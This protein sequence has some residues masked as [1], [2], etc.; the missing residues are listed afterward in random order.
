MKIDFNPHAAAQAQNARGPQAQPAP[1]A[2]EGSDDGVEITL[3]QAAKSIL[4]SGDGEY[5]GNS[6]AHKAR[7]FIATGLA[8]ASAEGG[9]TPDFSGPFGQI[10]KTFA[11]GHNKAPEVVEEPDVV[12]EDGGDVGGITEPT[13]GGDTTATD[14]TTVTDGTDGTGGTG[15]TDGGDTAV[16]D[17][18]DGGSET[19]TTE[20][21]DATVVA[22]PQ[23]GAGTGETDPIVVVE[24]PDIIEILDESAPG[25]G[26]A[27]EIGSGLAGSGDAVADGTDASGET[28]T[29]E[30]A[31]AAVVDGGDV[32]DELLELLDA[33]AEEVV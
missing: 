26:E 33:D 28:G 13:D 17:G 18:S 19:G 3:S 8:T 7:Q 32:T 12:P 6:P 9:E 4:K 29:T 23:D 21:D 1:P 5:D 31:P 27:G 20:G 16:T 14:G 30:G 2:P 10:V 25:D 22:A 15:T 11:P 24:E